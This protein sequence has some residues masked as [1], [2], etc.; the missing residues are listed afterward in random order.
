MIPCFNNVNLNTC[1]LLFS[2]VVPVVW[3]MVGVD[4]MWP[5]IALQNRPVLMYLSQSPPGVTQYMVTTAVATP[6]HGT[7]S[8]WVK[9][10]FPY[11][12]N[13]SS[14]AVAESCLSVHIYYNT[15]VAEIEQ[16]FINACFQCKARFP[17][18]R[19]YKR[20]NETANNQHISMHSHIQATP[21]YCVV[22][23]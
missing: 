2:C 12:R 1:A 15:I 16:T 17:S 4:L 7:H 5:G 9:T 19:Y 20:C 18:R 21:N 8:L 11:G 6:S 13:S 23:G 3:C 10:S 22:E 14:A